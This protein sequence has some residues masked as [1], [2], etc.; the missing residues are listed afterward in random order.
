[1]WPSKCPLSRCSSRRETIMRVRYIAVI[2]CGTFLGLNSFADPW[3]K[4]TMLTIEEPILIPG[5]T[6]QPGKY[7]LK[8]V[9]SLSDRHIVRIL[10]ERED[11]VIT[12]VLAIPNWRLQPT[13]KTQFMF[14]ETPAGNP[15]ALRAWFYP[16]DNFGQEFAYPKG[17]AAKI[18]AQAKAAVPTVAAVNPAA[19][20]TAP[21]ATVETPSSEPAIT[22]QALAPPVAKPES[23]PPAELP[24]QMPATGSLGP[25]LLLVGAVATAAGL[26]LR[27]SLKTR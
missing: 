26:L 27:T 10:N 22:A 16:G 2:A 18:A 8:L 24:Q 12:T 9:D 6:L 1:M 21:V 23:P 25:A 14:W 7:V 13:G 15:P 5:K 11:E 4:K 17:L 19:L 3:D 20:P